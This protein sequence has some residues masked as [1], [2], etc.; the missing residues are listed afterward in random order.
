MKAKFV[1][2]SDSVDFTPG[3][4]MAAGEIVRLGNL[5]GVV[6]LPIAAGTLGS[7]SLTGIF[8]VAKTSPVSFAAGECVCC[9]ADGKIGKS[10]ILLGTAVQPSPE[11]ADSVRI[12]LNC[13]ANAENESIDITGAASW[14]SL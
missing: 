7:L 11:Q 5:I 9:D 2:R 14:Q 8:D 3:K 10:G 6:K 12:L 1:Q 13:D 4:D